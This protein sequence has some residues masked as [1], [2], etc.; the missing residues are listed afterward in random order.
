MCHLTSAGST[1]WGEWDAATAHQT[2]TIRHNILTVH[3]AAC[4][5]L[6][7]LLERDSDR[8]IGWRVTSA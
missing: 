6:C 5:A 1:S 7:W 4:Q 2:P 3:S 8:L